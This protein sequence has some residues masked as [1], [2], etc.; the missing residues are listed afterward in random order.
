MNKKYIILQGQKRENKS[1]IQYAPILHRTK[2]LVLH[3]RYYDLSRDVN[4]KKRTYT[5]SWTNGKEVKALISFYPNDIKLSLA[6][7]IVN[8]I[9]AHSTVNLN[10]SE[11]ELLKTDNINDLKTMVNGIKRKPENYRKYNKLYLTLNGGK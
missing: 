7:K 11:N 4:T 2:N 3:R 9:Q 10:Q 6:K 1:E 5:I 8:F